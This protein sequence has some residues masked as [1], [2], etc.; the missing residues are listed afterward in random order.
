MLVDGTEYIKKA[1]LTWMAFLMAVVCVMDW[2]GSLEGS[3]ILS[4]LNHFDIPSWDFDRG[5]NIA[6]SYDV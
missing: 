6:R 1:M 4:K 5:L 3:F 2:P